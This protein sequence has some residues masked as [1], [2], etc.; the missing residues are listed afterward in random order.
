MSAWEQNDYYGFKHACEAHVGQI[1][2]DC[3]IGKMLKKMASDESII[4]ILEIGTWNG[5]GSTKC[6][7]D[8]LM[9]RTAPYKFY[10]LESNKDKCDFAKHYYKDVS[11]V[12]ILNEVILNERQSDEL[13]IFPDL[14]NEIQKSWHTVDIENMK[15]KPLFLNRSDIPDFFD[16]IFLDGGEYTTWHE[17]QILKNKCKYLILDDTNTS[18]CKKIVD[19]IKQAQNVWKIIFECN[20]RQGN[21]VAEKL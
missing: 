13:L 5:L 6:I 11:N 10:S 4:T 15:D 12:H 8:G 17:Y 2:I 18:K 21:I 1:T 9:Q 14:T 19:E 3:S 16:M 20:D 7:V